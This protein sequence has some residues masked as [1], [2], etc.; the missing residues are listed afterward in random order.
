MRPEKKRRTGIKNLKIKYNRVFGYSLEV[1]NSFKELVPENY[2]RKQTLTN[3]ERY[4]TQELKDLEDLILGAEDKLYALEYELFCE[5]RDKVGAEVVRI[6]K[7]AKAVAALDVFASL[8]LVA[9]EITMCA[10]RSMK[11]VSWIL[12]TADI[13]LWS[14]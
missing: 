10:R 14:R 12:K 13:R 4:I 6:Q 9:R 11:A 2:I 3:A 7:T 8:A 5:V 1:T